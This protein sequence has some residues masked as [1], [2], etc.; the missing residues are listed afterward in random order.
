MV[1][2]IIKIEKSL[3]LPFLQAVLENSSACIILAEASSGKIIYIN[4]AVRIFR[5]KT[6]APLD[7][8]A[9]KEYVLSWKDLFPDGTPMKNEE[10]PLARAILNDEII[11]N[12]EVIVEL[13]NGEYRW[14]LASASP[15]KDENGTTVAGIVSWLDITDYKEKQIELQKTKDEIKTLK[16]LIPICSSCKKI[17][18]DK[19]NWSQIEE[20]IRR[21]SEAEFS[22]G[23]CK[24]CIVKLYPDLDIYGK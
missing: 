12:E 18:D 4:N 20:Y 21:H 23:I 22:H 15:I 8:I 1:D 7:N 24:E 16:G 3:G 6:D 5:G 10:M 19:G 17:R 11:S 9:L 2:E 13:D 14:A